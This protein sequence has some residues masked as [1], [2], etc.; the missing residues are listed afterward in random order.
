MFIQLYVRR[1]VAYIPTTGVT[2]SGLYVDLEPV[3]VVPTS[4]RS[5]L[6]MA[7]E[8]TAQRGNPR[9]PEPG[10][11]GSSAVLRHAGVRSWGEFERNASLWALDE[12]DGRLR[13]IPHRRS[14]DGGWE[15]DLQSM[16]VLSSTAEIRDAV[17]RLASLVA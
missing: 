16:V 9:A 5:G 11:S 4:D 17:R 13:I 14:A 3:E 7:L 10:K 15:E 12:K 8:R 2:E 1:G 6:R